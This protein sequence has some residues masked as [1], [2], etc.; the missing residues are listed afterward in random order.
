MSIDSIIGVLLTK[1]PDQIKQDTS[2]TRVGAFQSRTVTVGGETCE[3]RELINELSKKINEADVQAPGDNIQKLKDTLRALSDSEVSQRDFVAKFFHTFSSRDSKVDKVEREA[4]IKI[5]QQK[6][7]M[8]LA[9]GKEL[10]FDKEPSTLKNALYGLNAL[11]S[12]KIFSID[13]ST[14]NRVKFYLNEDKKT[15]TYGPIPDKKQT[16]VELY[17][18]MITINTYKIA[19]AGDSEYTLDQIIELLSEKRP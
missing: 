7:L 15:Y 8:A 19:L 9:A 16:E 2:V 10:K 3:I 6:A 12:G 1:T 5:V 4:Q 13:A 14:V 17:I 11:R 18:Y